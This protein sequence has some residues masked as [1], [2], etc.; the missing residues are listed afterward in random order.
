MA[1]TLAHAAEE[2]HD[3]ESELS[4]RVRVFAVECARSP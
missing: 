1:R 2:L 3:I 4:Y